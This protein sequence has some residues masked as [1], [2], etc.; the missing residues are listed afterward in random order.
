MAMFDPNIF[1][2]NIFDTGLGGAPGAVG[3]VGVDGE[4]VRRRV[5]EDHLLHI[6]I[7]RPVIDHGVITADIR[8]IVSESLMIDASVRRQVKEQLLASGRVYTQGELHR[9]I[10]DVI[11]LLLLEQVD[12]LQEDY[13]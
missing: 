4:P 7:R 12:R 9:L 10:D 1:D 11:T 2:P 5:G 3:G 8:R 6:Q 13:T